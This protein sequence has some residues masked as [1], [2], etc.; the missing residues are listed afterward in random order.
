MATPAIALTSAVFTATT[1]S[2][3]AINTVGTWVVKLVSF[4][5]ACDDVKDRM[6][7]LQSE[8]ELCGI[9]LDLWR[10]KWKLSGATTTRWQKELW[11]DKTILI[12][13]KVTRIQARCCSFKEKFE[14]FFQP[15]LSKYL[16][17][18]ISS[19]HSIP[20]I[21]ALAAYRS[22]VKRN[23]SALKI[24]EFVRR[25]ETLGTK[26]VQDMQEW[27]ADL[28]EIADTAFFEKRGE[29]V[30]G[31]LTEAQLE[32]V[33]AS[34]LMKMA[35]ELRNASEGLYQSLKE[36]SA[37]QAFNRST[38]LKMDLTGARDG[39]QLQ[40]VESQTAIQLIYHL[41]LQWDRLP[42]ELCI[43]GPIDVNRLQGAADVL[44]AY[45]ASLIPRESTI[46]IDD[47]P[48]SKIF[49]SRL[50][51]EEERL[52][53]PNGNAVENA[54]WAPGS[55]AQFLVSL[56]DLDIISCMRLFSLSERISLAFK[57]VESAVLLAGTS[58]LSNMSSDSL[59]RSQ[60]G[61]GGGDYYNY[62]IDLDAPAQVTRKSFRR[63][64][65]HIFS[66]GVVLVEIGYGR[67]VV[68]FEY[69]QSHILQF[70]FHN[71]EKVVPIGAVKKQM[72]TN[73][74]S[75][76]A[77]MTV[78]CLEEIQYQCSKANQ[79]KGEKAD[80]AYKTILED[81]FVKAYLP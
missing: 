36:A 68:D 28:F 55:V 24:I 80:N 58:W 22:A 4:I 74:D 69:D 33:R 25:L 15:Q 75:K 77:S 19:G 44:S 37:R 76:Y 38:K 63:L 29:K 14:D 59:R 16:E 30:S 17:H 60:P 43:E 42:R 46:L 48:E 8:V 5:E 27:R 34:T 49:R 21:G 57:V 9:D 54:P 65:E 67:R 70:S 71:V 53:T 3:G 32:K 41:F 47:Q 1:G 52:F 66:V 72:T 23:V 7:V 81:Y 78:L 79:L 39:F 62:T 13:L 6:Q 20:S 2:I 31:P 10:K 35:V 11:G 56:D 73:I 50:P 51:R 18:V 61:G 45:E 40:S 64:A 12:G 26:W